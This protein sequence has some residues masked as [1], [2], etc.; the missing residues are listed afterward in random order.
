MF[1][2]S[3]GKELKEGARFCSRCGICLISEGK[4]EEKN[5]IKPEDNSLYVTTILV[6]SAILM[7]FLLIFILIQ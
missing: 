3:C 5:K 7:P 1:C 6:I 4:S 2:K